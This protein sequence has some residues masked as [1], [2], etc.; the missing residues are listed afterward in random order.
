M[1][2]RSRFRFQPVR[3]RIES[4]TYLLYNNTIGTDGMLTIAEQ[5]LWGI[6]N[7]KQDFTHLALERETEEL[8]NAI[9]R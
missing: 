6:A 2:R 1:D 7:D 8:L 3:D 9:V 4:D 5:I